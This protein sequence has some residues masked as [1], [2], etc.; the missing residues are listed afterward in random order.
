[1]IVLVKK[2]VF[3]LVKFTSNDDNNEERILYSSVAIV[4]A[5]ILQD[6]VGCSV[7]C[8]RSISSCSH[9]VCEMLFVVVAVVC[10]CSVAVFVCEK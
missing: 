1:L 2:P 6:L 4:I 9:K 10:C 8:Q 3:V 7:C 5:V